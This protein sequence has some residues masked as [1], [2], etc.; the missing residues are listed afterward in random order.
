[1][2]CNKTN[3]YD[4]ESH[5][6]EIYDQTETQVEDVDLLRELIGRDRRLRILEPFC[7]TGR[8]S[9]PL[10]NDG[11]EIVGMDDALSML[12]RANQK[13]DQLSP[14]LREKIS[15]VHTDVLSSCW[16]LAFDLVILGGNCF[17]E[18]ATPSEQ[19][20]CICK[21]AQSLLP[22]GFIY[23]DN[24]HMEGDLAEEWRE[25]RY[26]PTLH[27]GNMQGWYLGREY[28]RNSLG[29]CSPPPGKVS[30][31]DKSDPPGWEACGKG[32]HPPKTPC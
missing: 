12:N 23:I 9:I 22:G 3:P 17:Y 16:P 5:L 15:L 4:I 1:M 6:A 31:V 11:H 7:G 30:A 14:P 25:N 8:M 24:D 28:S 27:D 19:E 29:G 20:K 13:I 10:V 18:L 26:D 32:I 2:G 21:A